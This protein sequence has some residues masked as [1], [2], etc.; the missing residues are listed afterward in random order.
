MSVTVV[1]VFI[2]L[3]FRVYVEQHH[4]PID[5]MKLVSELGHPGP[6]S[7]DRKLKIWPK[8]YLGK[9][10]DLTQGPGFEFMKCQGAA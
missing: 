10:L 2:N 4:A 9:E 1:E 8:R 3:W 6:W 7:L 5:A